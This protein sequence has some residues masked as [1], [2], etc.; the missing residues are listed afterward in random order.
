M[1]DEL[2]EEERVQIAVA[3]HSFQIEPELSEKLFKR[4]AAPLASLSV[5]GAPKP[6]PM[7]L[8]CPECFTRHYDDG[9]WASHPHHTHAC[10]ACG[11][12]WRP[13]VVATVGVRFL[14][15]FRNVESQDSSK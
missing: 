2:T 14:P 5:D 10:Q 1:S 11:F 6:V 3:L 9:S 15:G 8:W 4:L 7:L 12:V 13:A